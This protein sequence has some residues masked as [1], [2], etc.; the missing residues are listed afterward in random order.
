VGDEHRRAGAVLQIARQPST[1]GMKPEKARI[2]PGA[3]RS[4]PR[5]ERVAHHR[6][7]RESAEHGVCGRD[8]GALPELVVQAGELLVGAKKVSRSG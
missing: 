7:H 6:A 2:P 1:L 3:G 4:A 8:A 5:A